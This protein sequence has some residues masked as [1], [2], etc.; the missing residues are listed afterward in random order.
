MLSYDSIEKIKNNLEK[1]TGMPGDTISQPTYFSAHYITQNV[2][3]TTAISQLDSSIMSSHRIVVPPDGESIPSL[4]KNNI[5]CDTVQTNNSSATRIL[6]FKD[7]YIPM[8]IRVIFGDSNTT[9][10]SGD[11]II[12]AGNKDFTGNVDD[13]LTLICKSDGTWLESGRS[14]NQG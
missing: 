8:I 1:Y 9:I 4:L 6:N 14:L 10:A 12:L 7:G 5:V 13:V 11:N 2:D 3:L